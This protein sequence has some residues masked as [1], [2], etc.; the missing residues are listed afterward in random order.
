M[1]AVPVVIVEEGGEASGTLIGVGVS[2]SVGPFAEGG[3]DEVF[4]LAIGFR[5]IGAS[6]A[7]L[8]AE[9]RRR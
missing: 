7:L 3:L 5:S 2:M 8:E 4:G 6:E 9:S 1:R